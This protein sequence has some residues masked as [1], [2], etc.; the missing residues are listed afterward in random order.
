M[1]RG[2]LGRDRAI[3]VNRPQC[4]P[5]PGQGTIDRRQMTPDQV[6]DTDA[7]DTSDVAKDLCDFA[8]RSCLDYSGDRTTHVFIHAVETVFPRQARPVGAIA[9]GLLR[10]RWPDR[11]PG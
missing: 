8:R 11:A 7:K 5:G 2:S 3:L 10:R 4:R 1:K 6:D 9:S